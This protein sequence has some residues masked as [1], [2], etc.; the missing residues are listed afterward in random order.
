M[1]C[2]SSDTHHFWLYKVFVT[3]KILSAFIF[4]VSSL[5]GFAQSCFFSKLSYPVKSLPVKSGRAGR[6]TLLF[7]SGSRH[8]LL[9]SLHPAFPQPPAIGPQKR[10]G[11]P[12]MMPHSSL[13]MSLSTRSSHWGICLRS[14]VKEITAINTSLLLEGLL[15]SV[16][17]YSG[18]YPGW[19][20]VLSAMTRLRQR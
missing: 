9:F 3:L 17:W 8:L 15:R 19:V 11:V 4:P 16:S 5:R 14:S 1:L 12:E 20:T 18:N 6:G 13:S 7:P 10:G 2:F